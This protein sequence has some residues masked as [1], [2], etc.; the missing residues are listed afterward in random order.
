MEKIVNLVVDAGN[1]R[2]KYA[3]FEDGHFLKAG[4]EPEYLPEEMSTWK[5]EGYA[6]EVF[7]SGSGKLEEDFC[8]SLKERADSWLEA[9]PGMPLPLQIGYTTPHTLGFDRIA[10]CTGAMGLFPASA[11]LVIDSGTAITFN[12][13]SKQGVFLGG[14][15]SPGLEM[16]F[17]SLHEYTARLPY[18]EPAEPYEGMGKSTEEAIRKGVMYG[19]L[20]EVESYIRE[21]K[22]KQPEGRVV[23]TGG[24]SFFLK[25]HLPA[26]VQ[27]CETLGLRGLN[28]IFRFAK[29]FNKSLK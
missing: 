1:T 24:N 11:L 28:E 2:T 12:Y 26:E 13:V 6:V 10:G 20:F 4:W 3:F 22:G 15:I 23:V 21:F 27:F 8:L 9:S 29:K 17:R 16:R 5:K 18:V 25:E 7:L 19:M 14:N